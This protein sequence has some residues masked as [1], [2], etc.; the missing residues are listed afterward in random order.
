MKPFDYHA[1]RAF[2]EEAGANYEKT[3]PVVYDWIDT[4]Y[5]RLAESPLTV[6]VWE[7]MQVLK[8]KETSCDQWEHPNYA[9]NRAYKVMRELGTLPPGVTID[10]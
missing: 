8:L 2:L 10:F 4:I 6:S 9:S 5:I 7:L 1:I 3:A